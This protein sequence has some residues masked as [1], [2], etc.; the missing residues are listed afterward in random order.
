MSVLLPGQGR[1]R[2]VTWRT[3]GAGASHNST[4]VDLCRGPLAWRF[5]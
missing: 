4:F 2:S 5:L 1:Q 3:D